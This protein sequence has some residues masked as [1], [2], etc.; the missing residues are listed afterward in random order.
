MIRVMSLWMT[1]SVW[2]A[3]AGCGAM[4]PKN[5]N[6]EA[7]GRWEKVRGQ[8]KL[9]LAQQ[10][11]EAGRTTDAELQLK[12]ALALDPSSPDAHILAARL[13]LERGELA[14]ARSFLNTA[15]Q[16][17][18]PS[19]ETEHLLGV[20]AE[21]THDLPAA[22]DHYGRAAELAPNDPAY[23]IARGEMLVA[24]GRTSEAMDLIRARRA[25]FAGNPA[26]C[27]FTGNV[28]SMLG[29]YTEAVDA[30]REAAL[31]TPGDLQ[32][33]IRLG[34]ALSRAGNYQEAISVLTPVVANRKDAP[35]SARLALGLAHL[36]HADATSAR[37]IF[38][39][40]AQLEPAN[41]D[42]FAYLARAAIRQ[43]DFATAR[44]S[45][46]KA[47][48]LAPKDAGHWLLL[49]Y[50]CNRQAD[51]ARA[52]VALNQALKLAPNDP[53]AHCLMGQLLESSGRS[54]AAVQHYRQALKADPSHPLARDLLAAAPR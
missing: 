40:A 14:G 34:T 23:V 47:C 1:A 28:H 2:M 37:D 45:I 41:A 52:Q 16:L 43:G 46:E 20:I 51:N 18:G 36:E 26:M 33:Q 50:V 8:V 27:T 53:V 4:A 24:L 3:L 32:A 31:I 11:L 9:Q 48:Q 17:D 7:Q 12:E 38:R 22:L 15:I 6:K 30:Y 35:W 54:A 44:Q 49:A 39:E 29:A 25:D 21:W 42:P 19:A 10:H 5:M 13:N